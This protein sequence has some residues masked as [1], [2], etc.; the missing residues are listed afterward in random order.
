[1]NILGSVFKRYRPSEEKL[2]KYGFVKQG[3]SFNYS[4]ELNNGDF[5]VYIKVVGDNVFSKIIDK[6][7]GDE[8]IAIDADSYEGAFIGD[9]R[10]EYKIRLEEI[11]E[12]CFFKVSFAFNQSNRLV[13]YIYK[14]YNEKP[15]FPF[16]DDD[17]TGVIRYH[18]N[19]KWYEI[20][21][22]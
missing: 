13:E 15:D 12:D 11:R 22:R 6:E 20:R 17:E 16:S 18:K 14:T 8:F 2:L 1:M 10:E 5:V 9:L 7:F 4:F 19:R 3:D 21:E